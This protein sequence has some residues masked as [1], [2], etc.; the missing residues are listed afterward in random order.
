[1]FY[2][3]RIL[4]EHQKMIQSPYLPTLVFY[5]TLMML[6]VIHVHAVIHA[7][8]LLTLVVLE[9]SLDK[10]G[11]TSFYS[12]MPQ[13]SLWLLALMLFYGLFLKIGEEPFFSLTFYGFTFD[14]LQGSIVYA[15]HF[16]LMFIIFLWISLVISIEK[17]L[18]RLQV[19][20]DGK[21]FPI[22]LIWNGT[23]GHVRQL[24][25]LKSSFEVAL[26]ARGQK[27]SVFRKWPLY[28][29]YMTRHYIS[30]LDGYVYSYTRFK[31][32]TMPDNSLKWGGVFLC[33]VLF[34]LI[35]ITKTKWDP[36]LN[37]FLHISLLMLI[38]LQLFVYLKSQG[39]AFRIVKKWLLVDYLI[40]FVFAL[41]WLFWIMGGAMFYRSDFKSF[42]F[43]T[44]LTS[45]QWISVLVVCMVGSLYH[46]KR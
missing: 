46:L 5:C 2:I 7:L 28:L 40:L 10:K 31:M 4:V 8:V 13:N 38:G 29:S 39:K 12:S 34:F 19:Y 42:F 9:R 43:I 21:L 41:Y 15:L 17:K 36:K 27:V 18:D 32:G 1:M 30:R 3:R 23:I 16:I 26:K 22:T 14:I 44:S 35:W 25:N 6:C 33:C 24:F 37:I 45:F 11:A 20:F